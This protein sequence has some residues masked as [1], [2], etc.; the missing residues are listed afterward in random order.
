MSWVVREAK[1]QLRG[2]AA[3]HPRPERHEL[4]LALRGRTSGL[5][6]S[7]IVWCACIW[8]GAVL[9][10]TAIAR[11]FDYTFLKGSAPNSSAA[12]L[13]T[14]WQ[15][16]A[17]VFAIAFP[18]FLLFAQF[19]R[20]PLVLA[21]SVA[22]VLLRASQADI[23][24]TFL[25]VSVLA[26]GAAALWL[27]S[28]S[29]VIIGFVTLLFPSILLLGWCYYR[30]IGLVLDPIELRARSAV[31]VKRQLRA[32]MT[33]A[34]VYARAGEL[35][36]AAFTARNVTLQ[37][38]RGASLLDPAAWEPLLT[39]REGFIADI[40]GDRLVEAIDEMRIV[41]QPIGD[42]ADPQAAAPP[43]EVLIGAWP[44]EQISRDRALVA[45][46]GINHHLNAAQ[47][48]EIQRT[49][50]RTIQREKRG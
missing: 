27:Q 42:A 16:M 11:D 50:E 19:A 43:F 17:A 25:L 39:G 4:E 48:A 38:M 37:T 30:A 20:E 21:K 32:S 46:R 24:G 23:A 15:V 29:A 7:T 8:A 49:I 41:A 9:I 36:H 6:L 45:V 12:A 26:L 5:A 1:R 14:M 18:L 35:L 13:L 28:D 40:E 10:G 34:W 31:I 2:A 3:N 22:Q 44:G 47:R 33:S